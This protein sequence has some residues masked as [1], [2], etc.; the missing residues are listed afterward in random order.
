[1]YEM[2]SRRTLV[3]VSDQSVFTLGR[4]RLGTKLVYQT[5]RHGNADPCSL[6]RYLNF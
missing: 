1:M 3:G 2:K 6:V 4:D 5:N